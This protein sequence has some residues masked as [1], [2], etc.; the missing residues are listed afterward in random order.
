MLRIDT[1]NQ[2]EQFTLLHNPYQ[3]AFFDALALRTPT[4]RHAFHR[5]ALISGRRGGKALALD[6]PVPTPTGWRT[7][8]DLA[9][10][11]EVFD[12]R[13]QPTPIVFITEVQHDRPCF[14]VRFSDGTEIV[15]DA[16]HQWQT[17]AKGQ[18]KHGKTTTHVVTTA[19]LATT[20]RAQ[21]ESNHSIALAGPLAYPTQTL[22]VDPYALGVWLGDGGSRVAVV[23]S[24]DPEIY[25]HLR[26]AGYTVT[27]KTAVANRCQAYGI[28]YATMRRDDV[29]GRF[30]STDSLHSA[31]RALN[32]LNNKHVPLAYLRGDVS[33]RLAL[34]QGLMDTD[35][36]VSARG[37]CEFDTTTEP[38]AIA[39]L[40]L[41]QSLGWRASKREGRARLYGRDC[42]PR[43]RVTF[44]PTTA[45]LPFRLPRKIARV[46][47][48]TRRANCR[49]VLSVTPCS[50]VPVR[51]LQVAAPSHLFLV[52]RACIPTHNTVAGALAAVQKSSEPNSLGWCVAPTYGDLHRFVIPAVFKVLPRSWLRPGRHGWSESKYEAYL[53]N[54]ATICFLS[55]EDDDRMR[56]VGLDWL[57]LDEARAI[58]PKVWDAV[59]PALSDKLGICWGTT[60]PNGYDWFYRKF[61]RPSLAGP[62]Q[63]AGYW[64]VQ[65][66][67]MDNPLFHTDPAYREEIEDARANSD[68]DWFDQEY[69]GRFVNF[70]GSIYSGK[71]ETLVWNASQMEQWI[72]TW[73][74]IPPQWP[75]VIGLDPGADHPFAA[76][77]IVV[78]PHGLVIVAEY[79]KRMTVFAEHANQLRPWAVGH[80]QVLWGI[81][82]SAIQAQIELAQMGITASAADNNVSAGIQRVLS[83]LHTR[84]IRIFGPAC[85]LLIE[86]MSSYHWRENLAPGTGEKRKEEPFKKDDDLVDA[87]RYAVM[88]WPQLPDAQEIVPERG[89]RA[90]PEES[91]WAW[92]REQRLQRRER[93]DLLD[94]SRDLSPLGDMFES[95]SAL[96]EYF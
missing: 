83:W 69:R 22:P 16:D 66:E 38:L 52:S 40:E 18:R 48:R 10:G 9:V 93:A 49:F 84:Q 71:F 67:T 15:A 62:K 95:T 3:Q 30:A 8:A 72:P 63:R 26:A 43:W 32:V 5:Y 6:T 41:L 77:K 58:N 60:S 34:V 31:L 64:A 21:G 89:G 75:V 94:W 28:G 55:A 17:L 76:V 88:T 47:T 35:G 65:Y 96:E 68:P 19:T 61:F 57:W 11:D 74:E 29:T 86:E 1:T 44:T 91:R 81:D 54:G 37:K 92:E 23:Y 12:D 90:V 82:K 46:R 4:G 42:G 79:C 56:G 51:C 73:P 13:G 80:H 27:M 59:R 70:Q 25:D 14:T 85:P 78:T 2:Q 53:I 36:T 24:Q 50:S 33:Q 20:V 7:I 45:Q 39:M 87:L